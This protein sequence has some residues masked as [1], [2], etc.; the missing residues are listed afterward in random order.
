MTALAVPVAGINA[1]K[2]KKHI[3]NDPHS[4]SLKKQIPVFADRYEKYTFARGSYLSYR[5]WHL[6]LREVA[7]RSL[8]LSLPQ[9]L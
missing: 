4:I 8:S 3:K 5:N 1:Y 9:L 7:V 6:S 2:Q